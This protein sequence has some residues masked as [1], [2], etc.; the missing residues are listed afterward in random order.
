MNSLQRT[1]VK[2]VAPE[3]IKWQQDVSDHMARMTGKMLYDEMAL[4]RLLRLVQ[5]SDIALADVEAEL[6]AARDDAR[7]S[8]ETA[9]ISAAMENGV[10]VAKMMEDNAG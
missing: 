6:L 8:L 5:N 4:S 7:M 9:W 10:D 1:I 2:I 3:L